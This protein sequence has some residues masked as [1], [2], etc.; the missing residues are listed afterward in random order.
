VVLA[1]TVTTTTG[2][3]ATSVNLVNGCPRTALGFFFR[4]AAFEVALFDVLGLAFLLVCVNALIPSRHREDLPFYERCKNEA[5]ASRA[6]EIAG[7][8]S[9]P[10]TDLALC[11]RGSGLKQIL[12]LER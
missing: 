7:L 12:S 8:T 5:R 6:R 1:F 9:S 10:R 2:L 11:I 3:F 4:F